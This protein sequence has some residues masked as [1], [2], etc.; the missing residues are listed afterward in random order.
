MHKISKLSTHDEK[1]FAERF[2]RLKS[3]LDIK[4]DSQLAK[5]L[6]MTQQSVA[7]A[8]KRNQIP[9]AWLETMG[10]LGISL[11]YIFFGTLPQKRNQIPDTAPKLSND[12]EKIIA[13][14]LVAIAIAETGY[15][16]SVSGRIFLENFV[17]RKLLENVKGEVVEVLK[18]VIASERNS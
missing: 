9:S 10:S 13:E 8:K 4:K 17:K 3:A 14:Q 7:G 6:K 5:I 11:D 18:D 12:P 2:E 15:A 16:P 1:L